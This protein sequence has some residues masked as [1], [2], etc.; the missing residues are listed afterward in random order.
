M[1]IR[2]YEMY[3]DSLVT[4]NGGALHTN[5]SRTNNLCFMY[6]PPS[7]MNR[8]C[9][10]TINHC[11]TWRNMH[12]KELNFE[13]MDWYLI[14]CAF[15]FLIKVKNDFFGESFVYLYIFY[16]IMPCFRIIFYN[17]LYRIFVKEK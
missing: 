13:K 17:E 11:Q 10:Y 5:V 1:N 16:D 3:K 15:K 8:I 4:F 14:G 7:H 2:K 12:Q 6:S 9:I